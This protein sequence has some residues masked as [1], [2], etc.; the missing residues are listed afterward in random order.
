MS[1]DFLGVPLGT[2]GKCHKH[3][4]VVLSVDVDKVHEDWSEEEITAFL[5]MAR[6]G[7]S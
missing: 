7:Y 6:L 5:G 2:T 1:F 4:R 3:M